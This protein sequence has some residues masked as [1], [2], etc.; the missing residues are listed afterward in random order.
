MQYH[1]EPEEHRY[2]PI[3]PDKIAGYLE[4][5]GSFASFFDHYEER[6][7]QLA[8][9]RA[10]TRCFNRSAVG[11]F[12]AGTGVGKSL[13]YLLPA[14]EWAH[15]NKVR[16][17][18]STGTINLQHQLIEKDVPAA[19][20]I[21]KGVPDDLQ[22]VLIK[23]RQNYLCL[24]RLVQTI[25]EPDLF[26]Q[27]SE[28]LKTIQKWAQ[29]CTEGS[30]SELP[31]MPSGGLWTKICSESDNCLG[32]RCAFYADCFVM[33]L[34]RKAEKA[35]VLIVN[36]HLLFA[37]L[38][39]RRDGA[40]YAGTAVLPSFNA[41][42]F[43]EAHTI[44]E[45][46]S[47]FFSRTFSRFELTRSITTLSRTKKGK[48]AGC[49][50]KITAVST[51]AELLPVII[52]ALAKTQTAYS[53]LEA[54]ALSF[55]GKTGSLSFT[56]VPASKTA[57][58]LSACKNFYGELCI[59]NVKLAVLITNAEPEENSPHEEAVRE[60]SL[61]LNRLQ[62]IAETLENF[63]R[64]KEL[65]D[66]VFWVEKIQTAGGEAPRFNQT[67][68]DLSGLLRQAVFTPFDTV[69]ALSA[70]LKIGS[71]FSYWLGRVGL[72]FFSDKP[73]ETASFESP[74]PYHT[75]VLLNIPADAPLPDEESF[76]DFVNTAVAEL[77]EMTGGKTLVLFTSY[78]SL[79]K[80]CAYTRT[81]L[82]DME[83]LQQ[84]EADRSRLLQ[85]FKENVESS[86]FATASFWAGIDVPGEALS[87]VI[88]VKLPFSVPTDPLFR[89]RADAIEEKGGSS[90]MQLSVP[91]AVVQF[92]Q[93]FG[94]LMRSQT[95][96]GIVT[97]LDKRAL[98]KQYGRIFI[99]SIPQTRQCFASLKEIVYTVENFLY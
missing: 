9:V 38:A 96:R 73:V 78:D 13:A 36:H 28:E 2:H 10:I 66:Q 87:H 26:S 59:L 41:V 14:F 75:N 49:L 88:L 91:E 39:S 46:A 40:G 84:G 64:W 74:F 6:P 45:A 86:L 58:L 80:A 95:D 16:I 30:R 8:L 56:Q 23:G 77:I 93:G 70:T 83:I 34:R 20:K 22:A 85:A 35:A 52:N 79:K 68:V 7:P 32:Q 90:F 4:E 27:E 60:G 69:I 19:L 17:V 98:I 43:D 44:E 97:L 31:F 61:T 54:Q 62:G 37:D 51:K 89:A 12:E 21:L 71:S 94:R 48:N 53:L 67:P 92:R 11:V 76:Q 24:R 47:G 15:T 18:I 82:P 25:Q 29:E 55:C 1:D 99:D 42:I 33:K 3:N 72:S 65:P 57:A 81:H 50:E 63:F 5:T